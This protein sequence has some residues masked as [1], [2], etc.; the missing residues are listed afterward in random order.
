MLCRL[1]AV[2]FCR[3]QCM[4]Q[5]LTDPRSRWAV[6]V[7]RLFAVGLATEKQCRAALGAAYSVPGVAAYRAAYAIG[8]ALEPLTDVAYAAAQFTS[9]ELGYQRALYL[10]LAAVP[11]LDRGS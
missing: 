3:R 5:R 10:A 6:E 9:A 4:W 11:E 7:T 8:I 2:A 1:A